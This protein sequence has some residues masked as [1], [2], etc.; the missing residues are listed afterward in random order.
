MFKRGRP[1]RSP[2]PSDYCIQHETDGLVK[3]TVEGMSD[4]EMEAQLEKLLRESRAEHLLGRLNE[5]ERAQKNRLEISNANC[6]RVLFK[7]L[8][9]VRLVV[10]RF[11]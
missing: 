5:L 2:R 3:P 6:L 4:K 9:Q 10:V 7:R 11:A 1:F 8:Q